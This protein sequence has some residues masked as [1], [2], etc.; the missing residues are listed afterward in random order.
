MWRQIASKFGVGAAGTNQVAKERLKEML[1]K[2]RTL[3]FDLDK[4]QG[5]VVA[6]ANKYFFV[7][8][9]GVTCNVVR[10]ANAGEAVE[11]HLPV[12]RRQQR[13]MA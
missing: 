10:H 9:G 11:L 13:T 3:D 6:L 5:D 1:N 8:T 2:Q 7:D 12:G 4:F